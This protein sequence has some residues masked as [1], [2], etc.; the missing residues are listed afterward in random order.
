MLLYFEHKLLGTSS[1]TKFEKHKLRKLVVKNL[2]YNAA[3]AG[4]LEKIPWRRKWQPTPA[5]LLGKFHGQ[6]NLVD[7]CLWGRKELDVTEYA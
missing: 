6:R 4:W 5:F 7:Y 3:D 2:P 1:G